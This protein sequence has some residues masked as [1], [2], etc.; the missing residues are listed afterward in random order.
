M[1][2]TRA[3]HRSNIKYMLKHHNKASVKT[4]VSELQELLK[5]CSSTGAEVQ[6][7]TSIGGTQVGPQD[8]SQLKEVLR[9]LIKVCSIFFLPLPPYL[10][11]EWIDAAECFVSWVDA[12]SAP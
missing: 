9:D 7:P 5:T 8:F 1:L 4:V 6:S 10:V 2:I 3:V 12:S 11:F